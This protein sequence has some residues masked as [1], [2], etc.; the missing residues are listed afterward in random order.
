VEEAALVYRGSF[1]T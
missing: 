1:W